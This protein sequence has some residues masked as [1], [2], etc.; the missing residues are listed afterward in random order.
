MTHDVIS[1]VS[2]L[3][4]VNTMVFNPESTALTNNRAATVYGLRTGLR[5]MK[6]LVETGAPDRST[7]DTSLPMSRETKSAGLATVAE[8]AVKRGFEP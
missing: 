2:F 7:T 8:H 1:S 5:N 3:A 4:R 6:C